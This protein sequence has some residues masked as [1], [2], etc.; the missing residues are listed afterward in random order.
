MRTCQLTAARSSAARSFSIR[1]TASPI[2]SSPVGTSRRQ[3]PTWLASGGALAKMRRRKIADQG[4][5]AETRHIGE[6][7]D[8]RQGGDAWQRRDRCLVAA[9]EDVDPRRRHRVAGE[10][11]MQAMLHLVDRRM[12]LRAYLRLAERDARRR[13]RRQASTAESPERSSAVRSVRSS[14]TTSSVSKRWPARI[15]ALAVVDLPAPLS[16]MKTAL[17]PPTAMALACRMSRPR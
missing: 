1:S 7:D 17:L 13:H 9:L 15:I 11:A 12:H 3:T 4:R 2:R 16:P 6:F 5:A 14:A 8:G 10:S